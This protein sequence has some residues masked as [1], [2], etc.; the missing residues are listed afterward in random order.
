[1]D[2]I[3]LPELPEPRKLWRAEIYSADQ[4]RTYARD[5]LAEY[6]RQKGGA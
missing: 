4:M 5:A 1:M 3:Q 2:D 6:D